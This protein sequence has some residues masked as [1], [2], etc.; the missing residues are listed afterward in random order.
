MATA[1]GDVLIGVMVERR[2]E[3]NPV[4]VYLLMRIRYVDGNH[5]FNALDDGGIETVVKSRLSA[6]FLGCG[7][8][9]CK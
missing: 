6:L 3:M 7:E 8:M 9:T 2:C 5:K 1:D 4:E